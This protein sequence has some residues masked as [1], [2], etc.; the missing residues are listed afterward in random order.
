M[1]SINTLE[2]NGVVKRK[3]TYIIDVTLS[4]LLSVSISI[5]FWGEVVLIVV[6]LINKITLSDSLICHHLKIC[7]TILLIILP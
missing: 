6:H 3:H 1:S 5:E 7:I 2:Q 4:F